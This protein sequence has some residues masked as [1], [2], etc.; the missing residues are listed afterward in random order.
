LAF[1]TGSILLL[2]SP[3]LLDA[4]APRESKQPSAAHP[5]NPGVKL[6]VSEKTTRRSSIIFASKSYHPNL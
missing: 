1:A 5:R 2:L 6:I 3:H 4:A